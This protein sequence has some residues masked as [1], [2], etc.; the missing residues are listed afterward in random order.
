MLSL[1]SHDGASQNAPRQ[2]GEV[3]PLAPPSAPLYDLKEKQS[4][5]GTPFHR[6]DIPSPLSQNSA[7]R[8]SNRLLILRIPNMK[9]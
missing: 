5:I 2:S 4:I 7:P 9:S 6:R 3:Q 8:E 1:Q